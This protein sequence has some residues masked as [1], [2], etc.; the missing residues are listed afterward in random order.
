MRGLKTIL[1]HVDASPRSAVR[2]RMARALATRH[3]AHVTALYAVTPAALEHPLSVMEGAAVVV[4]LLQ[5]LDEDRRREARARFDREQSGQLSVAWVE[6]CRTP[7]APNVAERSLASDLLVLGQHDP[8]DL[9]QAGVPADFATTVLVSGGRPALVVPHAGEF[10]DDVR[11][12]LV[13]WKPTPEAARAL[14]A[15]LP[16]L[17]RAQRVHVAAAP[18]LLAAD[19]RLGLFHWF[20]AHGLAERV[21][22]HAAPPDAQAGEGLLSLAADV[23]ADLLVMGCYGHGRLREFV[24]GGASR[25][26][27]QGMTLPVLM[28]H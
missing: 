4:P 6:D 1:V 3:G 16:L 15:A 5:Q 11:Q 22:S 28:S 14:H 27:L 10:P 20:S 13:A 24:L 17:S 23:D 12:V 25:T 7:L 18:G 2:L 26:V 8:D 19:D 9:Q 21:Q